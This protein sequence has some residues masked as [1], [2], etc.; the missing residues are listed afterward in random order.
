MYILKALEDVAWL[1][2]AKIENRGKVKATCS[3]TC[4][5]PISLRNKIIYNSQLLQLDEQYSAV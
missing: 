4:S 5:L 3:P 2:L 1:P